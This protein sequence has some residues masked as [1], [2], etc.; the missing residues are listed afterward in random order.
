MV[1]RKTI[2]PITLR[3]VVEICSLASQNGDLNVTIVSGKLDIGFS[4]AKEVLLEVEK[5]G[6][7]VHSRGLWTA[8]ENTNKFLE[9]FEREQWNEIH[10]FFL[11]NYQFYNE[12]IQVLQDH[13]MDE[14][15]LSVDEIKEASV[16]RKLHLNRTAVEVLA[17]WCE[18]LGV[19]QRNLYTGKLYLIKEWAGNVD[20]FLT[21]LVKFYRKLSFSPLRKEVFVEVPLIREEVCERL[22]I[23]R[24]IFDRLLKEVYLRNVGKIELSGAPIVTF[25]KRSPLSEK[26]MVPNRKKAII[27]PKFELRKEREGISIGQKFYYYIAIHNLNTRA[28]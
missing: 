5:M 2:R 9:C 11:S 23:S 8:S 28:P 15:G 12:F 13:I 26:M 19:I 17:G 14:Q 24:K 3:R 27:S 6:L 22:K 10:Q 1:E 18:R 20:D 21:T 4:R 25:A 7:L 16:K